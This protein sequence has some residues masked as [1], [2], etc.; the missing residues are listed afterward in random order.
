M[1]K[2]FGLIFFKDRDCLEKVGVYEKFFD[3]LAI[4]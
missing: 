4:K 3:V 2:Y 1:I